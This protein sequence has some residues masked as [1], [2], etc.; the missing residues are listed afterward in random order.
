MKIG[1]I[2]LAAGVLAITAVS[3]MAQSYTLDKVPPP[4]NAD[5]SFVIY[6]ENAVVVGRRALP[7]GKYTCKPMHI[8]GADLPVLTIRGD[9][10]TK[11]NIGVTIAPTFTSFAA[12]ETQATYYHI[13]NRYY[14]DRIWVRGLN[15]GYKFRLPKNVRRQVAE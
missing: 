9:N 3:S 10:G 7:P 6:L 11:L 4:M 13:G 14:L 1:K 2:T 8:A 5:D 12:A 15:Y